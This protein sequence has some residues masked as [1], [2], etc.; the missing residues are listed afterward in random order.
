MISHSQRIGT[1]FLALA[2]CCALA[3]TITTRDGKGYTGI[4]RFADA[5]H[6]SVGAIKGPQSKVA[7]TSVLMAAS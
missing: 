5:E 6:L 3:G 7:L 2:A 1:G 4:V